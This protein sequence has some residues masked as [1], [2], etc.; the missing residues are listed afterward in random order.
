[1]LK[2]RLFVRDINCSELTKSKGSASI[3]VRVF[4][5]C[6]YVV[7]NASEYCSYNGHAMNGT[8]LLANLLIKPYWA[9]DLL[10]KHIDTF[11][12]VV[13]FCFTCDTDWKVSILSRTNTNGVV[14]RWTGSLLWPFEWRTVVCWCSN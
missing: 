8:A 1:M 3:I 5:K 10:S 13:V 11:L 14:L 4:F 7:E 9:F 12:V 6:A 2:V